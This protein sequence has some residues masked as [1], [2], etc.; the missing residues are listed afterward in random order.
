[1]IL[2]WRETAELTVI[3][4]KPGTNDNW[5]AEEWHDL[6]EEWNQRKSDVWWPWR[7]TPDKQIQGFRSFVIVGHEDRIGTRW[8]TTCKTLVGSLE[9]SKKRDVSECKDNTGFTYIVLND[10]MG[11]LN[12]GAGLKS[13]VSQERAVRSSH[14]EDWE[15]KRRLSQGLGKDIGH[16]V[17]RQ[18]LP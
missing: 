11:T 12:E 6:D 3:R 17:L 7:W 13:S 9:G 5:S 8:Q 16:H 18:K 4:R 2:I 14:D 1:M 10:S 15:A